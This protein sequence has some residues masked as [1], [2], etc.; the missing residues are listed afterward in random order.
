MTKDQRSRLSLEAQQRPCRMA[1]HL[2]SPC[3]SAPL[4]ETSS[5]RLSPAHRLN[6]AQAYAAKGDI[7]AAERHVAATYSE[8]PDLKDGYARIGWQF[9]VLPRAGRCYSMRVVNRLGK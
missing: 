4:R 8:N 3:A 2:S 9:F 5:S 1:G 6:L 7:K